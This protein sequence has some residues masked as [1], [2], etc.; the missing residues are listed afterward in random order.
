MRKFYFLI[1][2]VLTSHSIFA[3]TIRYVTP[4]GSGTGTGSWGNASSDLQAMINASGSGDQVWV[5]KG[6]YYP[7]EKIAATTTG[8]TASIKRDQAFIL[9]TGVKI[10]GGFVGNEL[11]T[12][13]L[14]LR[15][16]VTNETI[17]SGDLGNASSPDGD[18]MLTNNAYHVVTAR[19]DVAGNEKAILDGFSIEDGYAS[20]T[21]V[22]NAG[23][24]IVRNQGAA[25][26]LGGA[27]A[28]SKIEFNNL[29]IRNNETTSGGGA[30][31]ILA[32]GTGTLTFTNTTFSDNKS[33]TSGGAVYILREAGQANF[34][35]DKTIFSG[36]QNGTATTR[37]GGAIYYS[38]AYDTDGTTVG[39]LT[40]K[41][42]K[43]IANVS[44][45]L[46]GA[47]GYISGRSNITNT[48]FSDNKS[49]TN[50]GAIYVSTGGTK[51]VTTIVNS[52][53]FRNDALT[54]SGAISYFGNVGATVNLYNNIF[55]GN[56]APATA[57]LRSSSDAILDFRN[58]LFQVF[59]MTAGAD[60][61]IQ[62]NYTNASPARL[63]A[64]TTSTDGNFLN[65]IEGEATQRGSNDLIPSGISTDLAGNPRITHGTVDLG[66]YE[67][68]GT[69][70]VALKS[71]YATKKGSTAVITWKTESEQNNQK[72]VIERGASASNLTFF[73]EVAGAGNS[74]ELL[75]YTITDYTPLAGVN[76]YRLT[77][78]DNDG[79]SKILDI[80]A[81]NFGL[82]EDKTT[83]Y[84]N[85]ARAYVNVKSNS[86]ENIVSLNLISLTGKNIL[87]NNYAQSAAQ[88]AVKLELADIPTGTY[89]L[90]INKG[91]PNAEKQRLLV[92]K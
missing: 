16:F 50:G 40:I 81:V 57:D 32:D 77:Q 2:I 13:D 92:V 78:Y 53:F 17:L 90:W 82:T 61:V 69:L 19:I 1:L 64:S 49:G 51:T 58:N 37:I 35:F 11:N 33:A 59:N 87:T 36:N 72:F 28:C 27:A 14:S 3:Q 68:Q 26:N 85:P 31:Y 89:I 76:Y 74:N 42:S 10:Y 60:D 66:A 63:F 73:K 5:A 48:V 75:S 83:V 6:T 39:V 23:L 62:D 79:T 12:F 15:N 45:G 25:I 55:N 54:S 7:T 41:N 47:I 91:K 9:R 86:S 34:I 20:A 52:T 88:E 4:N 29:I 65:L 84:P 56:T 38:N 80:D 30:V 24:D 43:F 71:F 44:G 18:G 21:G 8:G 46:A 67:F 70:P 22:L